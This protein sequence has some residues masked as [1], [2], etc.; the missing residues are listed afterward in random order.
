MLVGD[1][2]VVNDDSDVVVKDVNFG[3]SSG[4]RIVERAVF[5]T[6]DGH[7]YTVY[8]LD[9]FEKNYPELWANRV[10][11]PSDLPAPLWEGVANGERLRQA[12]VVAVAERT[13]DEPGTIENLTVTYEAAGRSHTVSN[14]FTYL[15][16]GDCT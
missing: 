12:T 11:V 2:L 1:W 10:V 9:D 5:A 4:V 3:S 15:I 16:A 7:G 14:R 6:Y 13:G 8:P